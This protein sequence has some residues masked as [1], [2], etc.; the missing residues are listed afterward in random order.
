MQEQ[1]LGYKQ[2]QD[3]IPATSAM[4]ATTGSLV[5]AA[6]SEAKNKQLT[7]L[8]LHQGDR[9]LLGMKKRGFGEGKVRRKQGD[10]LAMNPRLQIRRHSWRQTGL[11][12]SRA[13]IADQRL[14]RQNRER[15]ND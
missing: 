14:R 13:A 9:L 10:W 5:A 2:R 1:V 6:T 12:C 8:L 15:R 7:L 4:A 3:F 11:V